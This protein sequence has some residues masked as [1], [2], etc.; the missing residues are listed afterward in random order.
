M[1]SVIGKHDATDA[2]NSDTNT[3]LIKEIFLNGHLPV[4]CQY[5]QQDIFL[6]YNAACMG[7]S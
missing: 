4:N 2:S 3:N 1:Y 7:T 5:I 6:T